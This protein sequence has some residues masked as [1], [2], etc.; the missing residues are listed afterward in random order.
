MKGPDDN[1]R[2]GD[3]VRPSWATVDIE[4]RID[5]AALNY[6]NTNN[7]LNTK[8]PFVRVITYYNRSSP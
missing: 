6:L 3:R 4:I 8:T 2:I 5:P 7:L 1:D